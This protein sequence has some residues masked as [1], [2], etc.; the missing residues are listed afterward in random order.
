M[1]VTVSQTL[2]KNFNIE[3]LN[4]DTIEESF[5]KQQWDIPALLKVLESLL[6]EKLDHYAEHSVSDDDPDVKI[7]TCQ[8]LSCRGW[9]IDES[10]VIQN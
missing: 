1:Q 9:T 4:G 10:E 3:V 5:K 2:S 6:E 7:T 8:Y